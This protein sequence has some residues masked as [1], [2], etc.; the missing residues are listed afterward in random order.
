MTHAA[1]QV[2]ALFQLSD[3]DKQAS[4]PPAP[5]PVDRA[6]HAKHLIGRLMGLLVGTPWAALYLL[7]FGRA[8]VGFAVLA[9]LLA[10]VTY[11]LQFAR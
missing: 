6:R 2:S 10:V 5:F 9:A 8:D 1:F 7:G 3:S 11:A 4:L